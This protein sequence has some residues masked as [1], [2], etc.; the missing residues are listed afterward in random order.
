MTIKIGFGVMLSAYAT[1]GTER[2]ILP[3]VTS[4]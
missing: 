4:R 3:P 2:V 1:V